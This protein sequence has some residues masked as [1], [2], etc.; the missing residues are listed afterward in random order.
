MESSVLTG[1]SDI[2]LRQY[3][4]VLMRR[5]WLIAA[6][7]AAALAVAL[8][9]SLTAAPVYRAS[10]TIVVDRTSTSLGLVPDMTGLSPQSYMET[11]VEIIKSRSIAER[12]AMRLG[13]LEAERGVVLSKLQS[14]LR[15]QRVRGTDLIRIEVDGQTR[16]AASEQAN[17][18]AAALLSW[19][20]ESRR[21]QAA[22]GREFI[23]SQSAKVNGELRSA[24][25]ALA[26]YKAQGGQISL[27]EQTTQAINTVAS[28]E[29]QARA[30]TAERQAVEASLRQARISLGR[31]APAIASSATTLEDPVVAQLRSELERLEVELAGLR[32][33]FTDRHPQ[34]LATRARLDEVK[35]R[36]RQRQVRTVTTQAVTINAVHQHL[37]QQVIQLDVERQALRA[38]E[39]ALAAIVQ[40]YL[41]DARAFPSKELQLARLTRDVRVAEQTY[42]LL[43]Q[44]LHEARIGEAS[45]VGDL[46]IVDQAVPPAAPV[47]PRPR[48]YL[49]LGTAAGLMLGIAAVYLLEELDT[50]FR[51]PEEV[52]EVLGVPLLA[53]IP[54][55]RSS[56]RRRDGDE[57]IMLITAGRDRSPFAESFRQLRTNLQYINPDRPLRTVLITSPGPHESKSTVAANLSIALTQSGKRVWLVEC[58]LRK[59]ALAWAFQPATGFGLTELLVDGLPAEQALHRTAVENLW[60]LPGGDTKPPNP[61]ELLGSQ[62]MR[63]FLEQGR[64]GAEMLVLDAPP[65]LPVTDAAVLAPIV[66][67]VILVVYL[68]RTPRN[69]TRRARQQL[70]AVGARI[71]GVVVNGAPMSRRGSYSYYYSHDDDSEQG[72]GGAAQAR[73]QRRS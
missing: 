53:T 2:T 38:R 15:V 7:T 59:P 44:K 64:D 55:T 35:A 58:D 67:G 13:A 51:T 20:I 62:K 17:A 49:L 5:W 69:A 54:L 48:R 34:V 71:L 11:L 22:A 8:G 43:S 57:E 30:A 50:T 32:E 18:V 10:T 25:D 6:V 65:V 70:E 19:H 39:H 47:E 23:E 41:R 3:L 37:V 61:A 16:E 46:R 42:L 60:F 72:A 40:R 21:T 63:A 36:L 9:A 12:A 52:E 29:A 26:R 14:R 45:I 56:R 31:Q 68:G 66:D 33:Q 73:R 27:S 1:G 4:N 28:F 24:E